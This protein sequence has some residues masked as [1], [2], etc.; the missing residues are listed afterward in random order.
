MSCALTLSLH[1]SLIVFVPV[2]DNKHKPQVSSTPLQPANKYN[3][4]VDVFDG[5]QLSDTLSGFFGV[6][7]TST[8]NWQNRRWEW[9]YLML[10]FMLC[11]GWWVCFY[12]VFDW[13]Y[14][15]G[16]CFSTIF[17]AVMLKHCNLS[18][19]WHLLIIFLL[20]RFLFVVTNMKRIK[21]L[22]PMSTLW[23]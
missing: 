20:L 21:S 6:L 14:A 16:R 1:Y 15:R 19:C 2:S 5:T 9:V 13:V 8:P 12:F 23:W 18:C 7:E 11:V 10:C 22:R 4:S 17:P 3:P